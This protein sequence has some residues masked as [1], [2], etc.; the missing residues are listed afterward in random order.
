MTRTTITVLSLLTVVLLLSPALAWLR[1]PWEDATVVERS[2]LIVVARLKA[3]T[4]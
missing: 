3:G 4:I 2:E 1:P